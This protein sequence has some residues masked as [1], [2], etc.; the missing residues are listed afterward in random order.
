MCIV[1]LVIMC[2]VIV[3]LGGN[4]DKV[5]LLVFVDLVIDYLVIVDLF[6]CVD[7][8]ECNVEIEY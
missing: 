5:N 7:V 2:E 1:D 8:F 6:G 3:D 4:L